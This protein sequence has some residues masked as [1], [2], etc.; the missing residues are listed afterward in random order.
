MLRECCRFLPCQITAVGR[1][2]DWGMFDVVNHARAPGMRLADIVKVHVGIG[3]CESWGPCVCAF[4]TQ[5]FQSSSAC[6]GLGG[7]ET[8]QVV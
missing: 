7:A 2:S 8:M 6:S 1:V 5:H 4:I 3:M